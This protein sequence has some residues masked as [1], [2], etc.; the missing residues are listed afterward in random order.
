MANTS[1]DPSDLPQ[2]TEKHFVKITGKAEL[3][4][5]DLDGSIREF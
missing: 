5:R 2:N 1:Q 3:G 4:N